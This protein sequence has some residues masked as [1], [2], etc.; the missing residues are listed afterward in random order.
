MDDNSKFIRIRHTCIYNNG[1]CILYCNY[2]MACA[3][4]SILYYIY[5][6]SVRLRIWYIIYIK[7]DKLKLKILPSLPS[8]FIQT[9]TY[10]IYRRKYPS[11][12]RSTNYVVLFVVVIVVGFAACRS[13]FIPMIVNLSVFPIKCRLRLKIKT[14]IPNAKMN[15]S[16]GWHAELWRYI[17]YLRYSYIR[18]R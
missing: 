1:I 12:F 9:L 3:K 6:C 8:R 16:N 5:L 2:Y 7:K 17:F 15:L 14:K 11:E 4:I 13:H 10:Y 18:I